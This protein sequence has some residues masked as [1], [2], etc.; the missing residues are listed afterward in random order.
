M[1]EEWRPIPGWEGEYSISS[2]CRVRSE[3]RFVE[4][5]DGKQQPVR[6]CVLTPQDWGRVFLSRDGR[7]HSAYPP[8]LV[9]EVFGTD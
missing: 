8:R 6:E 4:K 2:R 1:T 3:E 7:K 5:S 9:A